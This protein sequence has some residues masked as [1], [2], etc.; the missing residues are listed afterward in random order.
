[1]SDKALFETANLLGQLIIAR[2]PEWVAVELLD[3]GA[4]AA[5]V[6]LKGAPTSANSGHLLDNSPKT[7]V[8][9]DL[10][11]DEARYGFRVR[12]TTVDVA[13]TYTVTIDGLAH[14][15]AA[16]AGDDE[17][18]ILTGLSDVINDG[19]SLGSLTL[20]M[21]DANPDTVTRSAGDF[22]A[23]PVV[24]EGSQIIL[25]NA[26]GLNDGAIFTA[27]ASTAPTATI[28]TCIPSDAVVAEAGVAYTVTTRRQVTATVESRTFRGATVFTLVISVRHA[29]DQSDVWGALSTREKYV[30]LPELAGQTTV[31][32]IAVAAD[33]TGALEYD[34]DAT[35][36]DL[37]MH[38]T[39]RGKNPPSGW[40]CP[41]ELRFTA[42]DFRGFDERIS[43]A[44]CTRADIEIAS[45]DGIVARAYLGYA[46]QED[47]S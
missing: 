3:D 25:A 8:V 32:T 35:T 33:G 40:R 18:A 12:V 41:N 27:H 22:T 7:R 42:L 36:C 10:R 6:S 30:K 38:V 13:A 9:V 21:V 46:I 29:L 2:R 15:Y 31:P 19:V 16:G 4:L 39:A 20:T 43:T 34:K 24:S 45:A 1:M 28:F 37:F 11:E 44:G 47:A 14:D 17:E 26:A 23:A 5:P